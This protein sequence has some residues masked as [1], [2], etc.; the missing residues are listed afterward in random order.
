MMCKKLDLDY[1]YGNQAEQFSFFRLP[2]VLVKDKKFKGLSSDAKLLYGIMLDRMSLSIKNGWRDSFNRVYIIFTLEE[3]MR[4]FD[5]SERKASMLMSELDAKNGIGLIERKR[6]GMGKPN[7]IY[8]KNFITAEEKISE[9]AVEEEEYNIVQI[10]SGKILQLYKSEEYMIAGEESQEQSLISN[11][12][13]EEA[14]EIPNSSGGED[15]VPSQSSKILQVKS[16]KN[17]Q[18]LSGKDLQIKS[19]KILQG[20]NTE[21]NNTDFSNTE[22]NETSSIHPP[23]QAVPTADDVMDQIEIITSFIKQNI[24]YDD[25]KQNLWYGTGRLLD[26]IVQLLVETIMVERKV[27]RIAGAEYPYSFVKERLLS[28]DAY[29]IEYVLEC[30]E[31]NKSKIHNIKA[32]LITALFN[33]PATIDS[34]YMAEAHYDGMI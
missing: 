30:L 6:Q 23:I 16:S 9:Q 13:P 20:N 24:G 15:K 28:L 29:H 26:E 32:Y 33:A 31:Q 4:E 8:L 12:I 11:K 10:Q 18:V 25:L 21:E 5:C 7:L 3:V 17:L 19:S 14:R 34:Y 22:M 2:K 27:V 1:Y